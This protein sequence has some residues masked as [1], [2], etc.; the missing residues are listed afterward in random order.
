[1]PLSPVPTSW[2]S[3]SQTVPTPNRAVVTSGSANRWARAHQT[4]WF[5]DH[6]ADDFTATMADGS[7]VTRDDLVSG[8]VVPSTLGFGGIDRRAIAAMSERLALLYIGSDDGSARW[9]VEEVDQTGQLIR[10]RQFDER[11][12]VAAANH[13]DAVLLSDHRHDQ[14]W[15]SEASVAFLRAHRERN[16]S[17]LDSSLHPEFE[18]VDR[19]ELGY[20]SIDRQT[21]IDLF[22]LEPVGASA[23][24][25]QEAFAGSEA[26]VVSLSTQ[27]TLGDTGG[28]WESVVALSVL[29]QRDGRVAR[30]EL[31]HDGDL[32]AAMARLHELN[33]E[34]GADE[35]CNR[36]DRA[37][38]AYARDVAGGTVAST[39]VLADDAVVDDRRHM[40]RNTYVGRNAII[41]GW[42]TTGTIRPWQ[43]EFD[44]LAVRG[45]NLALTAAHFAKVDD[46]DTVVQNAHVCRLNADR[47]LDRIVLFDLEDLEAAVDELDRLWA[48]SLDTTDL[49][50]HRELT[51]IDLHYG[52]LDSGDLDTAMVVYHPSSMFIDH[53]PL[54]WG[55]LDLTGIRDRM[56]SLTESPDGFYFYKRRTVR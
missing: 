46:P 3:S 38:R 4:E 36:A 50:E 5:L 24:I 47:A 44:T 17:D 56:R 18:L 34:E 39:R 6:V 53:R 43:V 30:L 29:E 32:D 26:C 12:I 21:F 23:I 49:L 20:S 13:H 35:A 28:L 48:E 2:R 8:A 42:R 37:G 19:R 51:V 45:E 52:G 55:A 31:F 25:V 22:A 40:L 27:Y 54:G 10:I 41:E 11:S 1:M 33:A 7:T 9:S 14:P 15:W 16:L